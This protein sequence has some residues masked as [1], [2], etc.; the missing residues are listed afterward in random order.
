MS[1]SEILLI[2]SEI[3]LHGEVHVAVNLVSLSN[4]NTLVNAIQR[5]LITKYRLYLYLSEENHKNNNSWVEY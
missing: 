1:T 5:H 2:N 4:I 3:A